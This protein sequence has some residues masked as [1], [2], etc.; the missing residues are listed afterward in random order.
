M[1]KKPIDY[2][3][4]SIKMLNELKKN[5]PTF[6]MGRHIAIA[7]ADYGDV[8]GIPDR[9]FFFALEKYAT[10]L[11]LDSTPLASDDEILKLSE[12]AD[13]WLIDEDYE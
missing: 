1:T 2:Y 4:K 10:E 6:N 11:E 3:S 5:Y 13:R 7:F 12:D 9:E 8:W